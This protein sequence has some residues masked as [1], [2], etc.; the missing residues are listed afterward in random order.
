MKKACYFN[1]KGLLIK[2]I[3][4]SMRNAWIK[5]SMHGTEM[6]GVSVINFLKYSTEHLP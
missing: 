3:R 5:D 4:I 2:K 6:G 1:E